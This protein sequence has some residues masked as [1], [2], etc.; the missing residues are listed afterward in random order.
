MSISGNNHSS[1]NSGSRTS[2]FEA[3]HTPS[4]G[5]DNFEVQPQ[6]IIIQP[7]R[8]YAR[9]P[10]VAQGVL[11]LN[12]QTG[13]SSSLHSL[14]REEV[15]KTEEEEIFDEDED[16]S[17]ENAVT[18]LWMSCSPGRDFTDEEEEEEEEEVAPSQEEEEDEGDEVQ[19]ESSDDGL[20]LSKLAGK[21]F[22]EKGL[23]PPSAKRIK[24]VK[25]LK[26]RKDKK[27]PKKPLS[28]YAFF[29]RDTQ[30]AIKS[31]NPQATFG[32]IS[33]IVASM[34]DR[35]DG[36]LKED[37]N[38]R[39]EENKKEYIKQLAE[40]CALNKDKIPSSAKSKQ[41]KPKKPSSSSKPKHKPMETDSPTESQDRVA[42]ES[43][44]KDETDNMETSRRSSESSE[45]MMSPKQD[46]KQ[47]KPRPIC[48]YTK[49]QNPAIDDP[50]WEN[51]YCSSEC[52][53][54]H[55]K[56]VF[57]A[58]VANRKSAYCET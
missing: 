44:P 41:K 32:E 55:C 17:G 10:V 24:Q 27:G 15:S 43:D 19:S 53:I 14:S 7:I 35:L 38:K 6:P 5:D 1:G 42:E 11:T 9:Q 45:R 51:N 46:E 33:K 50:R 25:P 8:T 23:K 56:D 52:V 48:N 34:W 21:R 12:S 37:Y 57:N 28:A 22:L 26:I 58:W 40:Y 39:A 47:E 4:F 30:M 20:P 29:Y 49:C 31:Q 16:S 2:I 18:T 54:L 3:F 13:S 36:E